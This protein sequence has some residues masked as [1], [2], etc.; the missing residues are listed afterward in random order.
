MREGPALPGC[1]H[2][3]KAMRR[4]LGA[5][6]VLGLLFAVV[7]V[8]PVA[9]GTRQSVTMSV[10]TF[11][12]V[13]PS[14]FTASIEGCTQGDTYSAGKAVF[15]PPNGVFV[16]YKLFDCNGGGETGFLVRLN[17]RFSYSGGSVG[18]WTIVHA[19]GDL[20]G[21]TGSG[22]LVGIPIEGENGIADNYFGTV[23]R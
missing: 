16:G 1:T 18:S 23:T 22:K 7:F 15:P 19:W 8:M 5:S 21:M 2:R 9:A 12:D 10:A 14:Q 3:R 20:A 13:D 11:F 6:V 4:F 17:A